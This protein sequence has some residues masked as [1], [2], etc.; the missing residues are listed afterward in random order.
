MQRDRLLDRERHP[1]Q[2]RQLRLAS[3]AGHPGRDPP[4][5]GSRLPPRRIEAFGHDRVD[6]RGKAKVALD[7]CLQDFG[8]GDLAVS[9]GPGEVERRAL[10]QGCNQGQ[11]R[12]MT[13]AVKRS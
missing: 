6:P 13:R 1:E 7:V 8:R 9:D 3:V 10:R 2:R 4:V 12:P 11:M 5:G